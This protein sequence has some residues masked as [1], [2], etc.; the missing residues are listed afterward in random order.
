LKTVRG[1]GFARE[2]IRLG[3]GKRDVAKAIL[4]LFG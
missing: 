3:A 4:G 1:G 2:A